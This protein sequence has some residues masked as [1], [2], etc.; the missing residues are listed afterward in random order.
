MPLVRLRDIALGFR[1]KFDGSTGVLYP[2]PAKH[3]SRAQF[4]IFRV[5]AGDLTEWYPPH[6]IIELDPWTGARLA[7]RRV[8]PGELGLGENGVA[9]AR[10]LF[11]DPSFDA[12]AALRATEVIETLQPDV[13]EWFI[14][15]R[16][17]TPSE[18]QLVSRYAGAWSTIVPSHQRPIYRTLSSEFEAWLADSA[19]R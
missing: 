1:S 2:A 6:Q 4:P 13:W 7:R 16:S 5:S 3:P 14:G 10:R 8:R 9:Q 11:S 18:R 12:N 19:R 17:L 15:E